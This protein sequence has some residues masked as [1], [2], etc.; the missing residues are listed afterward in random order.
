MK[1][2][3]SN[4]F[5]ETDEMFL[6]QYMLIDFFQTNKQ[7]IKQ[8]SK[9]PTVQGLLFYNLRHRCPADIPSEL[10]AASTL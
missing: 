2:E 10:V 8:T 4:V 9:R 7:T 6:N 3:R 1:S 5:E